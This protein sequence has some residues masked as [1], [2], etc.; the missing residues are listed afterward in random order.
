[1]FGVFEKNTRAWSIKEL[2]GT[3]GGRKKADFSDWIERV[4]K[5]GGEGGFLAPPAITT[6]TRGGRR[7]EEK[8]TKVGTL[9]HDMDMN[10]GRRKK[11]FYG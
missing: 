11:R 3:V 8:V 6:P 10:W 4:G 5:G 2:V 1:L 9:A 7:E